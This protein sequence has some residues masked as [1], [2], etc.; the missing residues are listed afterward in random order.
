MKMVLRV[1]GILKCLERSLTEFGFGFG[2]GPRPPGPLKT[3]EEA[4]VCV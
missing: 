1:P 3:Q 2:Q 4:L